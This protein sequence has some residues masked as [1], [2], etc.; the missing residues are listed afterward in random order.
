MVIR[1]NKTRKFENGQKLSKNGSINNYNIYF[2][3]MTNASKTLIPHYIKI[4]RN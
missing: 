2:S 3:M 1:I 4:I